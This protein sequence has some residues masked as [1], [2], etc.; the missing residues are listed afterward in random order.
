[1]CNV[2]ICK[3]K[4]RKLLTRKLQNPIDHEGSPGIRKRVVERPPT[5]WNPRLFG[6][7]NDPGDQGVTCVDP[8]KI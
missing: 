8:I 2:T 7:P 6:Q 5:S 4:Q 1:M 3:K